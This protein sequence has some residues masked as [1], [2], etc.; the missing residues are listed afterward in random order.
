MQ[1]ESE[2]STAALTIREEHMNNISTVSEMGK[3]LIMM[4]SKMIHDKT[5]NLAILGLFVLDVMGKDSFEGKVYKLKIV[6]PILRSSTISTKNKIA[7]VLVLVNLIMFGV[8]IQQIIMRM[9]TS[10]EMNR[11]LSG[12]VTCCSIAICI[13]VLFLSRVRVYLLDYCS[14]IPFSASIQSLK[15]KIT[16]HSDKIL[17]NLLRHTC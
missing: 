9:E 15:E 4:L 7:V 14:C 2:N 16:V 3:S 1:N 8:A 17:K 13:E 5:R 10:E 11:I 12:W 6:D